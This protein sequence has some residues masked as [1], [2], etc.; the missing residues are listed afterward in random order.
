MLL[1]YVL[2]ISKIFCFPNLMHELWKTHSRYNFKSSNQHFHGQVK[3]LILNKI[4][5]GVIPLG[6]VNCWEICILSTLMHIFLVWFL[7][8]LCQRL[9]WAIFMTSLRNL[10]D[11][12]LLRVFCRLELNELFGIMYCKCSHPYFSCLILLK[13]CKRTN[14]LLEL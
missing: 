5:E 10:A 14:K 4:Q 8:H 2:I 13:L 6:N 11:Q 9:V 1:T 7:L 12:I 3:N